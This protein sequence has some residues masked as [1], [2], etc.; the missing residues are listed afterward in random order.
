MLEE[1]AFIQWC[2]SR[3][4]AMLELNLNDGDRTILNL[5]LVDAEQRL[6]GET[7]ERQDIDTRKQ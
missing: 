2:I 3:Y 1:V 4:G 5:L 7:D 6:K